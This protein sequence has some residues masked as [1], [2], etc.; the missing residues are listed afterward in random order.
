MELSRILACAAAS[1]DR[2]G[3]LPQKLSNVDLNIQCD[4]VMKSFLL[5][6]KK[7]FTDWQAPSP[8]EKSSIQSFFQS[9]FW[10]HMAQTE[11]RAHLS[12][13]E[14]SISKGDFSMLMFEDV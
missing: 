3:N 12:L 9:K 13:S 6:G 5:D 14:W 11:L 1:Q 7:E 8:A 4:A 2:D 10:Q